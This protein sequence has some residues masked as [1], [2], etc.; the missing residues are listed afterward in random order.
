VRR[1]GIAITIATSWVGVVAGHFVAYVLAYPM[2][3]PRHAHLAVTGHSWVGL[4]TVSLL[5]VVPVVLLAV[6]VR[7]V[8]SEGSWSESALALRLIA[9]QVPAFGLIEVMERQWSAGRT[10]TDPAVFIGLVL[11]PLIA[12]LAT[13][14][15]DLFGRAVRAIV[16]RIRR[17]PHRAPRGLPRPGL[18]QS[19]LRDE[20]VLP[21]RRRAP[22]LPSGG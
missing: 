12:V 21:V 20:L 13:W 9:I 8:R 16:A 2:A 6:A 11:L 19:R 5:A 22:P 17:V 1:P 7:A 4:A 3:G 10:V 18:L 14:L 15:L